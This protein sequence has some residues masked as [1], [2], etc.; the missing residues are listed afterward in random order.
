MVRKVA[1][2]R[3]PKAAAFHLFTASSAED[4]T[5]AFVVSM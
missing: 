4:I 1:I 2:K 5:H 3:A